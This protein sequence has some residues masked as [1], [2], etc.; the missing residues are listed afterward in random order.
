MYTNEPIFLSPA[1]Q[2]RIWGG[3]KLET[4]FDYKIPNNHTGEAWVISGHKNGPSIIKNGPLKGKNLRRIWKRYPTIFG[5]DEMTE[6]FPLLVKILDANDNLSVQVHPDDTYAQ[7][8]E[9]EPFGKTE[10]WYVLDCEPSAEIIFGHTAKS[11]KEFRD[12]VT[13]GEWDCLLQRIPVKKGDF[14][15]VPNGTIHAIGEGIVILE[16]QQSS[17]ITYRVYDYNRRDEQGNRR[18]LHIDQA[19]EVTNFPGNVKQQTREKRRVGPLEETKF[20][21]APYF[22]VYYWKL[23]GHI[24]TPLTNRNLLVNIIEG[25]GEVVINNEQ[26]PVKKGD[27]F[28][29]P[30]SI[31]K[32]ALS[33]Q[34][35]LIISHE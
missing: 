32:Y 10:C 25:S 17:D 18:E 22:T 7:A 13:N 28:I 33:G 6:E 8:N 20:V 24:N 4:L 2:E 1:F 29:V 12:K 35:E 21:A 19:I 14:F 5:Y 30:V 34:L 27:H 11:A 23:K 16:I 3:N 26:F 31:E 9:N 15:Y